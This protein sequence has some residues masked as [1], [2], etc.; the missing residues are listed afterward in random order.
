MS[1]TS[2]KALWNICSLYCCIDYFLLYFCVWS[3]L[4]IYY[5]QTGCLS[6]SFLSRL[7]LL[8]SYQFC[9]VLYPEKKYFWL[10][11]SS[12]FTILSSSREKK[13]MVEFCFWLLVYL[14]EM[15]VLVSITELRPES[16]SWLSLLLLF[17]AILRCMG[18]S[19][20]KKLLV[21]FETWFWVLWMAMKASGL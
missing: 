3:S 5:C 7:F 8:M 1:S 16:R 17:E 2:L 10:T 4:T 14:A 11:W 13:S 15:D 21:N 9:L 19:R 12:K 6:S 18:F 20:M